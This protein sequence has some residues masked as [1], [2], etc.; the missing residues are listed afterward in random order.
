[1]KLYETS[2]VMEYFLVSLHSL[3]AF[4]VILRGQR[5]GWALH[6]FSYSI[7]NSHFMCVDPL[8]YCCYLHLLFHSFL[9]DFPFKLWLVV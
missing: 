1:M 2:I 8:L 7:S 9:L 3:F 5:I 6:I 4:T